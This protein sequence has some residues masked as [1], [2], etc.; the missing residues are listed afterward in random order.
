MQMYVLKEVEWGGEGG[1]DWSQ[2]LRSFV[3]FLEKSRNL[4]AYE[5]FTEALYG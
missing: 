4:S 1:G 2:Y 5:H 3:I